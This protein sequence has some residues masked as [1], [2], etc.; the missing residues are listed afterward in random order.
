M[1]DPSKF[2]SEQWA[3]LNGYETANNITFGFHATSDTS[4]STQH[5]LFSNTKWLCA[6]GTDSNLSLGVI[7]SKRDNGSTSQL[8]LI[9]DSYYG[10]VLGDTI[11]IS[12]TLTLFCRRINTISK[13]F[14]MKNTA[15]KD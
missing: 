9:L 15:K 5:S 14:N 6:E 12:Y 7:L 10:R 3:S 1:V 11:N 13:E 2:T 4:G 8:V